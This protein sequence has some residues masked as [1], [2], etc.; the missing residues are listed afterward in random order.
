[1]SIQEGSNDK[2]DSLVAMVKNNSPKI[3]H[4]KKTLLNNPVEHID[5]K[6]SMQEKLL[7]G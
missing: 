6:C 2:V 1:M 3:G 7:L 4:N 5:I